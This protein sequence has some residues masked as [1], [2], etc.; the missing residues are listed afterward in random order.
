[1]K[2]LLGASAETFIQPMGLSKPL[3]LAT[4]PFSL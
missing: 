2:K 4:V 3:S 1:M